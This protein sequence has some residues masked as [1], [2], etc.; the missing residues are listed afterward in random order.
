[1]A[2]N[3]ANI[4]NPAQLGYIAPQREV[5]PREEVQKVATPQKVETPLKLRTRGLAKDQFQKAEALRNISGETQAP[6]ARVQKHSP[7][8][9]QRLAQSLA[10]NTSFTGD[11]A[12]VAQPQPKKPEEKKLSDTN[13]ERK[14]AR[15]VREGK[16]TEANALIRKQVTDAFAHRD[17]DSA[18]KWIG[19]QKKVL[20]GKLSYP[21][22]DLV[23]DG[24]MPSTTARGLIGG[25]HEEGDLLNNIAAT[26][27]AGSVAD[28]KQATFLRNRSAA[29]RTAPPVPS[30]AAKPATASDRALS[31][32]KVL[33][34]SGVAPWDGPKQLEHA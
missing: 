22:P 26:P 6:A 31:I 32:A 4:N 16:T 25:K 15:L 3:G 7:E 33:V 8:V 29:E 14:V 34:A 24:Q 10:T 17:I 19:L 1:M 18:N 11:I 13:A 28:A 9:A 12:Q 23:A 21:T 20:S 2:A 5:A 27:G 30:Y